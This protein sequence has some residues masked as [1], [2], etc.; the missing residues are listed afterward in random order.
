MRR[1]IIKW[2]SVWEIWLQAAHSIVIP[3]MASARLERTLLSTPMTNKLASFPAT[4]L[5]TLSGRPILLHWIAGI[6]TFW[7]TMGANGS[8][9]SLQTRRSKRNAISFKKNAEVWLVQR[10]YMVCWV[11]NGR[12]WFLCWLHLPASLDSLRSLVLVPIT[13]TGLLLM[14]E[15]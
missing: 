6:V 12:G 10:R 11:Y 2:E 15:K 13:Y 3:L 1:R 5:L 7:K 9:I 8:K 14:A 4:Y